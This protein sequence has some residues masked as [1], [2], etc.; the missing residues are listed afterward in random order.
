VVFI[1]RRKLTHI[2]AFESCTQVRT[3]IS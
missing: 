3:D 2:H 1:Q